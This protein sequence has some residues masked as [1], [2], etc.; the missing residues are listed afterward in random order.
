M[1]GSQFDDIS[2]KLAHRSSRREAVR[3]GGIMAALAGAFGARSV[4]RAQSDDEETTDCEWAFKALV[5]AGPNKDATYDGI[6]RVEIE[7]DGAIDRGTLEPEDG[8]PFDVV[9]N[10]RGK[11]I[12]LVVKP[13]ELLSLHLTG[14]GSRDIKSCQGQIAGTFAGPEF[15]DHGIWL[16]TRR[17]RAD[18]D[19]DDDFV[20]FPTP[21]SPGG[22]NPGP[23]NPSPTPGSNTTPCPPEDCGVTKMWDPNQCKCVC[24]DNGVDCGPNTCCPQGAVCH[25]GGGCS[26]PPGTVLCNTACVAECG[27]GTSLNYTTCACDQGCQ[28]GEVICN[29]NCI[30]ACDQD[31]Q[32][33][34]STCQCVST[35]GSGGKVCNG[36]CKDVINDILNCGSCGNSCP[37]GQPCIAGTCKCPPGLDYY[38][39]NSFKCAASQND[40]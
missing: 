1:D 12:S 15:G 24:Y 8:E 28:S 39:T 34:T 20:A 5:V 18:E 36:V 21:T 22:G 2:R 37:L 7:R 10:T 6:M 26:C 9:G 16:I 35:C 30:T 4:A 33:N 14:A 3:A 32:L 27:A 29:G 19:D 31:H 25:S 17:P 40:C 11:A 13:S 38:C 23:G